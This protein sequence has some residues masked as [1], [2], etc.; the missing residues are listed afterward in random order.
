[1][2]VRE[3]A[4]IGRRFETSFDREGELDQPDALRLFVVIADHGSLSAVARRAL[5]PSTATLT[6]QR[7]QARVVALPDPQLRTS[8]ARGLAAGYRHRRGRR[9]I[10]VN[11]NRAT[12]WR[13]TGQRA[14]VELAVAEWGAR[15]RGAGP[16]ALRP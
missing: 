16:K 11:W 9:R 14:A 3:G 15:V 5:S 13:S 6:L 12:A 2:I 8:A 7:L 10:H 4:R 1:M